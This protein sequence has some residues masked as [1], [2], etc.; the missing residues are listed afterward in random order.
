MSIEIRLC[1]FLELEHASRL[2]QWQDLMNIAK[3]FLQHPT[4][5]K[6]FAKQLAEAIHYHRSL[7]GSS[8]AYEGAT[9]LD[10]QFCKLATPIARIGFGNAPPLID[11]LKAELYYS[12]YYPEKFNRDEIERAIR[13]I[14]A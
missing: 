11:Y 8:K 9:E 1:N 5:N 14:M 4:D 3:E 7:M 12:Q 13:E 6:K 10:M 2:S